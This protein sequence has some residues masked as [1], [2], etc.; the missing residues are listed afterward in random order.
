MK[1]SNIVNIN[2]TIPHISFLQRF[3]NIYRY[4]FIALDRIGV[5]IIEYICLK[6]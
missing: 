3:N 6:I 1:K 4:I 2:L 5:I